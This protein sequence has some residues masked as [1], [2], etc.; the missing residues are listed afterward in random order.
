MKLKA[1]SLILAILTSVCVQ[2]ILCAQ[3]GFTNSSSSVKQNIQDLK[4]F[5]LGKTLDFCSK[6]HMEFAM[7]FLQNQLDQIMLNVE[8]EEKKARKE[9]NNQRRNRMKGQLMLLKLRQHFLDRHL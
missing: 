9:E 4:E 2:S 5:C 8:K 3:K 1:L 6:M 7:A